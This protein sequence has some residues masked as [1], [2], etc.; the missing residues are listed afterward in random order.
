MELGLFQQQTMKLVMTNQLR[1][2][3]SILQYSRQEL[4]EFIQEEALENPLI[5]LKEPSFE[6][7]GTPFQKRTDE[8][9]NPFDHIEGKGFDLKEDLLQQGRCLHLSGQ[10]HKLVAYLIHYV[11]DDGY[12]QADIAEI[13][14]EIR[15]PAEDAQQALAIVQKLE[16]AGIGARNLQECLLLQIDRHAPDNTI[17]KEIVANG[18]ELLAEQKWEV[19]A[20]RLS[21]PIQSVE[22]AGQLIRQL[23]PRPGAGYTK[24]TPNFIIPDLTIKKEQGSY[25]V[26]IHDQ[27]LPKVRLNRQYSGL[28]AQTPQN[29]TSRYVHEK[30]KQMNWLVKS[31]E[32][33][34]LTLLRVTEA[35][36][37][38]QYKF[39]NEGPRALIPLT[40]KEIAEGIDVHESTVSRAVKGKYAQ[41]PLGLYELKSFFN[42]KVNTNKSQGVSSMSVKLLLKEMVT[43]E[44]NGHPLS[45]QKI[46][47]MLK[48]E[49]DIAISRR[50][51]A[52]YREE[53]NIP[54]SSKRKNRQ[55][56]FVFNADANSRM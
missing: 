45:D 1:Q 24:E 26:M 49:N 20:T 35:I 34:Q 50:T 13:A 36:V 32:Q 3:I 14:E 22:E 46:S 5:E 17:A 38:K 43:S 29:E 4:T 55:N 39:L 8:T 44:N 2:A 19:L 40:L 10:M 6:E 7:S 11:D 41:T 28:L 42:S 53:L 54:S 37:N 21:V 25:V 12:F 23:Q 18:L 15:R 48:K 30:Y 52:K 16:P 47:A 9:Y 27:Y 33:R 56:S 31:I 51:V